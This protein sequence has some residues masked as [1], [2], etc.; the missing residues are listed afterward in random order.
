[1]MIDSMNNGD[2]NFYYAS[3]HIIID[4]NY[5]WWDDEDAEYVLIDRL[6][7]HSNR[8]LWVNNSNTF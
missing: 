2:D 3:F 7:Q 6:K 5:N 1:M 8:S 4:G